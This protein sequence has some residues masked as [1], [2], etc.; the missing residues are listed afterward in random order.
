MIGHNHIKE[1]EVMVNSNMTG[2]THLIVGTLTGIGCAYLENKLGLDMSLSK[3]LVV[4]G[5]AIGS[6][7]PDIDIENSLLGRFIPGWL[8]WRHRTVTHSILFMIVIGIMGLVLKIN[9]GFTAG[10][11]VGIGTHL[12]LDAMTPRG[13][14]YLLFPLIVRRGY[15]R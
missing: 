2:K 8:F 10:M 15:R 1:N 13:L 4:V 6:L 5:C 3:L 14:P 7:L 12:V 11:V 9:L